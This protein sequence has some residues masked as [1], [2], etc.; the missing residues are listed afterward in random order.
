MPHRFKVSAKS[1]ELEFQRL[2]VAVLMQPFFGVAGKE[3]DGVTANIV[4]ASVQTPLFDAAVIDQALKVVGVTK[5]EK[6]VPDFIGAHA[7]IADPWMKRRRL[8]QEDERS[9]AVVFELGAAVD[10]A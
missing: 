8:I 3:F 6:S 2:Q 10:V 7:D 1:K 5:S 4:S 9:L